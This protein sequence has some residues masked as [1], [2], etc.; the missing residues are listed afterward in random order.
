MKPED[1]LFRCSS[2]GHVMTE[3]KENITEKQLASIEVMKKEKETL[4]NANGNKVKWS[5]T[6]EDTLKALLD[7]K[8]R[9]WQPA[10]T[11]INDLSDIYVRDRYNRHSDIYAKPLEKGNEVEENSITTIS[12]VTKQFLQ[13]NE[14][15]LKNK[16]IMGTPD[17][18][19]GESFQKAKTIRDAKSSFQVFS[20]NR[21]INKTLD[22]MYYW[23]VMGYMDLTGAE[24]AYVDYCLNNTPYHMI[25]RMLYVESFQH[26]DNDTP[27]WMELQLITNHVY[28][29]DTFD[30]V[31]AHRGIDLSSKYCDVIY[32][33]FIE[34]PLEERHFAFHVERNDD[35]IERMYEQCEKTRQWMVD[36]M[37]VRTVKKLAT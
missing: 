20:F 13:K 21:S 33:S 17:L 1:I 11:S 7:K 37:C 29:Q 16:W 9:P 24:E 5:D 14:E 31:I 19:T 15:H 2:L 4:V 25:D 12:R 3:S 22:K 8:D 26:E 18:F 36:N 27:A 30:K 23:Q 6:K 32:E 35:E 34:I 28:D 10:A